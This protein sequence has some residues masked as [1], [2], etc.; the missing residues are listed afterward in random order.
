MKALTLIKK[1]LLLTALSPLTGLERMVSTFAGCT[2]LT[3]VP[4]A[5]FDSCLKLTSAEG[6]FMNCTGLRGESPY[7]DVSGTKVHLYERNA[8]PAEFAPIS[9][10]YL[11]YFGCTGLSDY[12]EMPATWKK[13]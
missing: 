3:T 5:F 2:S 10:G 7:T 1:A 4:A 13:P 12:T 8:Y 6:I 9:S 11:C